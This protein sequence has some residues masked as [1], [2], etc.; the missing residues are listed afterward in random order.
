MQACGAS[1]GSSMSIKL[2]EPPSGS[3]PAVATEAVGSEDYSTFSHGNTAHSRLPCLLCHRR[4]GNSAQPVRSVGHTPCAGCHQQQ[5]SQSRGAICTICHENIEAGNRAAKPFPSLKSFNMVFDH[6]RHKD[7]SCAK[8]HKPDRKGM[9][10]S[11]PSGLSA[12]NTCFECHGARAQVAGRDISSCVTCHKPGSYQ[13]TP[14]WS[15]AYSVS[16][17]HAKH[18]AGIA[19]SCSQCHSV[20]AGAVNEVSSPAPLMHHVSSRAQSC[21]TCHNNKRAF[22]EDFASC[23]RCHQGQTFRYR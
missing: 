3:S 21:M 5:F 16:F 23:K 2:K 11:I 6:S 15:R 22:G 13:S 1:N 10:Q 8:C 4:E 12:H 17:S 7:V 18:A 14:E 9:A 20:R 19:I